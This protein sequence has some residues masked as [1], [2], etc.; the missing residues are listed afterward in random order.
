MAS[1]AF[2]FVDWCRF[3][4][5]EFVHSAS[6]SESS[7]TTFTPPSSWAVESDLIIDWPFLVV[8]GGTGWLRYWIFSVKCH[9]IFLCLD[10][11]ESL[12]LFVKLCLRDMRRK[13]V[14]HVSNRKWALKRVGPGHFSTINGFTASTF[15]V[16]SNPT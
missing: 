8:A 12:P 2:D 13:L 6:T 11:F 7:A 3:R 5:F 1:T 15:R 4:L 10:T 16:K 9:G 14:P